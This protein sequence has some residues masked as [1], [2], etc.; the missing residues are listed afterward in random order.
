MDEENRQKLKA[1][2]RDDTYR[3][4][5]TFGLYVRNDLGLWTPN[6]P[7]MQQDD[8]NGLEPDGASIFIVKALWDY[9]HGIKLEP[10]ANSTHLYPSLKTID[11]A[12]QYLDD[13]IDESNRQAVKALTV[14]DLA[15]PP[16]TLLLY[17]QDKLGLE[18]RNNTLM[19][20]PELRAVHPYD[21]STHLLRV[22]WD[23][24]QNESKL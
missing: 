6:N 22:L 16:P 19:Q 12:V 1:I 13:E 18:R 10:S 15:H 9:L 7:L 4:H 3:L 24:L 11:E 5:F 17:V 20:L 23:R 21:V 14:Y 2:E 8:L